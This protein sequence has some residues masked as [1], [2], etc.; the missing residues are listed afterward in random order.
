MN[1]SCA[2]R[3]GQALLSSSW[4][5]SS[6]QL[7]SGGA[8]VSNNARAAFGSVEQVLNVCTLPRQTRR[9]TAVVGCDR[10]MEVPLTTQQYEVS[11]RLHRR[12]RA[13]FVRSSNISNV[14]VKVSYSQPFSLSVSI[15]KHCTQLT[16]LLN[17]LQATVA[18]LRL[19]RCNSLINTRIA[20]SGTARITAAQVSK[21]NL[22]SLPAWMAVKGVKRAQV[23]FKKAASWIQPTFVSRAVDRSEV[24]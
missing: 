11:I 14:S 9:T 7:R 24:S 8:G 6:T 16:A 2:P 12:R 10:Q 22:V 3:Q 15:S 20:M 1:A 13:P 23:T 17:S 5:C 21:S 4:S 18:Y 19:L